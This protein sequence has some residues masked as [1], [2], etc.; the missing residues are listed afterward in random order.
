[1]RVQDL[2]DVNWQAMQ[3]V[4]MKL[5]S[6]FDSKNVN[7]HELIA[8][9]GVMFLTA[10]KRMD[11]RPADVLD[12]MGNIIHH[13]K[14]GAIVGPGK[15]VIEALEMWLLKEFKDREYRPHEREVSERIGRML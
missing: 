13:M 5:M 7:N 12:R 3:M 6:T 1:M 15:R 8:A 14:R 4:V 9:L 11:L 10:C 2:D